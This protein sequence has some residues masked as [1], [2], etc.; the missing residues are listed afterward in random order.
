MPIPESQLQTW[1]NAGA[2][3]MSQKSHESIRAALDSAQWAAGANFE[4]FL[5]GSY[6][7]G[8]NI[9]GDSDV[10][11]VVQLNSTWQYDITALPPDQQAAFHARYGNASYG[12]DAFRG[13]VLRALREYY[14]WGKVIEGRKS[15][16][17]A[18]PYLPVDVVPCL[19]Y[20]KYRAFGS[21][22]GEHYVEGMT[23]H[24]PTEGRWVVNYPKVHYANG[25]AKNSSTGQWF[26]PAV[27]ML[28]NA[29]S[30]LVDKYALQKGLVPSYF[31]ECL[32]H[33]VP[34]NKFGDDHQATYCGIVEWLGSVDLSTCRCQN[35]QLPLFGAGSDQWNTTTARQFQQALVK[36]WNEWYASASLLY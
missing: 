7:N 25:T 3:V 24:V 23:F 34:D 21:L 16:K 31:L 30:Y 19:H 27:R 36:L 10:D 9:R 26:K 32:L 28:K 4:V 29:R 2:L 20:R 5:Q 13:D 6:R 33:S 12:W 18:T 15:I 1:A 22:L 11:V 35:G 17:V 14:G 8:T